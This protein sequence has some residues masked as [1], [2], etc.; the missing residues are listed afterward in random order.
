VNEK[1]RSDFPILQNKIYG[2]SLVYLDNAATTQLPSSVIE[3][4]CEH[5]RLYNGNVHRGN[6]YLS[7]KSSLHMNI[8]R[9]KTAEFINS[10][11]IE[12]I[13]FTSGTTESI[14][15]VALSFVEKILNENDE[16]IVSE[17]EHHSNFVVWQQLCSRKKAVLKVIPS[18]NGNLDIDQY[19]KMLNSRVKIVALTQVS[20]VTGTVT[21]IN[22]M[23]KAAHK[24]NI[25]V[26]VDGAQAI[27]H[28]K[29]DVCEMD[30][31]FYCFSAHK[32]MGPAGVGVLYVKK[33]WLEFLNP[34]KYGGGMVDQVTHDFTTL[35]EMPYRFEAGTPNYPS[36]IGLGEAI[37]YLNSIGIENIAS[38]EKELIDYLEDKLSNYNNIKILGRPKERAGVLCF[39]VDGIHPY[40]LASFLDKMGV[41]V[42][43]GTHC[44]QPVYKSLNIA[45]SVRVSPAFY[46]TFAEIDYFCNCLEKTINMLKK[47]S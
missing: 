44:A 12:Q 41:A 33:K 42:R 20:N 16:I 13:I 47:W 22:E 11:S 21:E 7:E 29:N 1:I 40:D 24:E 45:S 19:K 38:Y 9:K 43:A 23:I 10:P 32:M 2:N 46:N 31:D 37:D 36:I 30:C 8:A 25:P 3:C 4:I 39:N 28:L 27:R 18:N 14:N 17:L 15:S 5:Y 34:Y 26:L 35:G 6:H